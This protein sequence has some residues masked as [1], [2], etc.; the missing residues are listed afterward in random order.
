MVSTIEN[1]FRR[2]NEKKKDGQ[3]NNIIWTSYT[4][5]TVLSKSLDTPLEKK[6]KSF[7]FV[8]TLNC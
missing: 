3:Y 2:Q 1:L 7:G 4:K 6:H 5:D 8:M